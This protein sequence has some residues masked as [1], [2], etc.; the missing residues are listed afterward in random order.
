MSGAMIVLFGSDECRTLDA[1][2]GT[3][4]VPS[5][6]FNLRMFVF[7]NR[8]NALQQT[9]PSLLVL[10]LRT[11]NSVATFDP[12]ELLAICPSAEMRVLLLMDR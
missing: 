7:T 12:G 4:I 1:L 6:R 9:R 11:F 8:A 10:W 5:D 3:G 2:L